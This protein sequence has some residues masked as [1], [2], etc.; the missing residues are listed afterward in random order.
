MSHGSYPLGAKLAATFVQTTQPALN[1]DDSIRDYFSALKAT[2]VESAFL[3]QRT[4]P[5]DLQKELL[6]GLID[7]CLT[8]QKEVNALKLINLPFTPKEQAIF[9]KH[10]HNSGL[11]AAQDTLIIRRLHQ[12][13]LD[14]ALVA[15]R[16]A[17][18]QN[19]PELDGL[20]WAGLANG[21]SLGI[22]PRRPPNEE[23]A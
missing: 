7:H 14:E 1:T 10:I 5:E 15:A 9:E 18:Y 23:T 22:G 21:L 20:S 11:P 4:V 12:G 3:Y 16:S 2:S 13:Q 19:E 17:H 8:F 6:T